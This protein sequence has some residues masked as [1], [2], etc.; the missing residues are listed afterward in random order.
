MDGHRV[1][2]ALGAGGVRLRRRTRSCCRSVG[3]KTTFALGSAALIAVYERLQQRDVAGGVGRAGPEGGLVGLVPDLVGL[4]AA[5]VARGQ[6]ADERGVGARVGAHAAEA[7]DDE[8]RLDPA[9]LLLGDDVVVAAVG[10]GLA[11][12][13]HEVPGPLRPWCRRACAQLSALD[14]A[15][16]PFMFRP[17]SAAGAAAGNASAA[18]RIR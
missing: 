6:A 16:P 15:A 10:R 2:V 14:A 8:E 3:A 7:G 18:S 11:V 9:P 17:I 12:P 13:D 5:A 4:D 1:E